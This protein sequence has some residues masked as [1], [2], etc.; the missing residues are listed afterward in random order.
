MPNTPNLAMPLLFAAQAQK[1][2]THN[3]ALVVI[4]ALLPGC[5]QAVA[6]DPSL[7]D[8][9]GGEAWIVGADPV[10]AWA[11]RAGQIAISTEGGWRF[12][13]PVD[14]MRLKDRTEGIVLAFDGTAWLEPPAIGA[15]TGG[16]IV[17]TEAR[18]TIAALLSALHQVGIL[19][20]T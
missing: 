5:V 20:A 3:E 1:E 9:A 7:L 17:D 10:G 8:P 18:A 19:K 4:D 11:S 16:T 12:V 6:S 15:P 2:M 13:P 14:G